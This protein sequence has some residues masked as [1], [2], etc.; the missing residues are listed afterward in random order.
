MVETY[1][2]L[3]QQRGLPV[4]QNRVYDTM[5]QALA[6]PSGD[7]ELVQNLQTGLIF[8]KAFRQDLVVYDSASRLSGFNYHSHSWL[9]SWVSI[10]LSGVSVSS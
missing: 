2:L 9:G 6:C 3:Y 5:E 10:K 7:V 4:A 8:N 1:K